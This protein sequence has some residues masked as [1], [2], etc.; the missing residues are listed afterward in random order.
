M[1]DHRDYD[2]LMDPRSPGLLNGDVIA[3]GVLCMY[4]HSAHI[5]P[6]VSVVHTKHAPPHTENVGQSASRRARGP[7]LRPVRHISKARPCPAGSRPNQATIGS[8]GIS[9]MESVQHGYDPA[10]ESPLCGVN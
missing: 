9:G 10:P 1:R 2:V 5:V 8:P 3:R 7:A 4:T 6:G